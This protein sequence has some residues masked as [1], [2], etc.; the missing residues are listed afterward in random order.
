M[1]SRLNCCGARRQGAP[2]GAGLRNGD[3]AI[4]DASQGLVA[5]ETGLY[6]SEAIKGLRH[7]ALRCKFALPVQ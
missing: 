7:A 2:G 4:R 3:R 1:R 6:N 5:F